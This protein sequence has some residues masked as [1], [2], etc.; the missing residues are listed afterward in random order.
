[1]AAPAPPSI[2]YQAEVVDN[3]TNSNLDPVRYRRGWWLQESPNKGFGFDK[4][5]WKHALS[6]N[7]V[8]HSAVRHPDSVRH[9]GGQ[10]WNHTKSALLMQCSYDQI[11]KCLPDRRVSV[12]VSIGY[13]NFHGYGQ[14]GIVTAF[15][16]GYTE[17]P[18]WV[19]RTAS[20]GST[21]NLVYY[22]WPPATPSS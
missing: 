2:S 16:E 18:N 17:C 22:E 9:L 6:N 10:R 5:Y 19:N 1:M 20:G 3:F 21:D 11:P 4:A 13:N 12:L 14:Q 7:A 8:V 15:C